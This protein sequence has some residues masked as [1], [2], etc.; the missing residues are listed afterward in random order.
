M[1]VDP[2][3]LS[4]GNSASRELERGV[5]AARRLSAVLTASPHLL[6]S[7]QHLSIPL[8]SELLVSLSSTLFPVLQKISFTV[9]ALQD[10]DISCCQRFIA[11]PSLREVELTN[12]CGALDVD[13]LSSIFEPCTQNLDSITFG[14]FPI[15]PTRGLDISAPVPPRNRESRAGIK[16]LKLY[17]PDNLVIWLLSPSSPF[18]LTSLVGVEIEDGPGAWCKRPS[19]DPH[20]DFRPTPYKPTV[21]SRRLLPTESF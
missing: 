15:K 21:H 6:H 19:P 17:K 9:P 1:D 12:S 10:N 18:D 7:I 13:H 2:H 11:L 16:K 14:G 5:A 8:K 4:R 3:V 20:L